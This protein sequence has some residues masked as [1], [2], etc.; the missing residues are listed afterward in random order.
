M[1]RVE[2]ITLIQVS[3]TFSN[4]NAVINGFT[5]TFYKNEF[6]VIT[7]VSGVGKTTLL[8]LIGLL[9]CP[10]QGE[11]LYDGISYQN[12]SE[13][14]KQRFI[15][16]HISYLFQGTNLNVDLTLRDNLL[17]VSRDL[18]AIE[19][20]TGSLQIQPLLNQK[21]LK[22]SKGEKARAALARTLLED[23][24]ILVLD[25]PAANL[26]DEK[27][28]LIYQVIK[29]Y[30]Q[31]K[32]VFM[33]SHKKTLELSYSHR[34]LDLSKE[35]FS[36][37]RVEHSQEYPSKVLTASK[38][39]N[40]PLVK[41]SAFLYKKHPIKLGVFLAL[42]TLLFL[43]LILLTASLSL[44]ESQVINNRL[45][46]THLYYIPSKNPHANDAYL[47]QRLAFSYQGDFISADSYFSKDDQ[48]RFKR[49]T[50]HLL[51]NE[52]I[53]PKY[54]SEQYSIE[55]GD[56][57]TLFNQAI[58]VKSIYDESL[59]T[60]LD[61]LDSNL[62]PAKYETVI[63]ETIPLFVSSNVLRA[64][65]EAQ[66][67]SLD[68]KWFTQ[69]SQTLK[70][71]T[72]LSLAFRMLNL[73]SAPSL[74]E[75]DEII[76]SVS[77]LLKTDYETVLNGLISK[78]ITLNNKILNSEFGVKDYPNTVR[79]KDIIYED[80]LNPYDVGF[81]INET[82]RLAILEGLFDNEVI[83]HKTWM[84]PIYEDFKIDVKQLDIET[85]EIYSK[86]ELDLF[87]MNEKYE[88]VVVAVTVLITLLILLTYLLVSN[89]VYKDYRSINHLY[90]TIGI[91]TYKRVF[92]Y[93][94]P[95]H[96][97]TLVAIL[98][99]MFIL[100][101]PLFMRSI[102]DMFGFKEDFIIPN[103]SNYFMYGVVSVLVIMGFLGYFR[104]RVK[105][106]TLYTSI[107]D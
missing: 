52:M 18:Q 58:T 93:T 54:I 17:L 102:N 99:S 75:A 74:L 43:L 8:Q 79:I 67:A 98:M 91:P 84:F 11:I 44:K 71:E 95:L 88:L 101:R 16:S 12:Q 6:M 20:I 89:G 104:I 2:S 7:G 19:E 100:K 22:L 24:S 35:G 92:I 49:E 73:K 57:I 83:T 21:V 85:Y 48:F 36:E 13:Q 65:S 82:Y 5:N 34:L 78:S 31:D 76:L 63:R 45:L 9:D 15:Q 30:T 70:Q 56:T 37:K 38:G 28:N 86:V 59:E 68:S 32:I 25:E 50:F 26:D 77:S 61:E 29:T 53:I 23:K 80:A 103:L 90:Y 33:V 106:D 39:L 87:K 27:T 42:E 55:I 41:T 94:M 1:N 60:Y 66:G 51:D 46:A 72:N 97:L 14:V 69:A 3:K 4:Q 40:K 105:S 81:Y 96:G 10:T 64:Y 47:K 62:Q 107:K